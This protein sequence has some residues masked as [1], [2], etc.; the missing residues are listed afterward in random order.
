MKISFIN[1]ND[2]CMA[3][4]I[5]PR[6]QNTQCDV[7][8]NKFRGYEV[9]FDACH[10]SHFPKIHHAPWNSVI[11][12]LQGIKHQFMK[13]QHRYYLLRHHHKSNTCLWLC[14]EKDRG[15][16]LLSFLIFGCFILQFI[17]F[18]SHIKWNCNIYIICF[19]WNIFCTIS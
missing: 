17:E 8:W 18:I 13:E 19:G 14:Q 10:V 12:A 2:K 7:I 16:K 9:H 11:F 5:N 15:Q 4:K 3:R 1:K 6:I